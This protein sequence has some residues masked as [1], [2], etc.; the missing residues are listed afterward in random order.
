MISYEN[1]LNLTIG[2]YKKFY[3]T[4]KPFQ[5]RTLHPL[6]FGFVIDCWHSGVSNNT[7]LIQKT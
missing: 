1:Y 4:I 7:K 2:S 5:F 6:L 3:A